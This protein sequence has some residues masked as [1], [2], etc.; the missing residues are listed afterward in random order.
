MSQ[1][2]LTPNNPGSIVGQGELIFSGYF[3]GPEFS[4]NVTIPAGAYY[5]RSNVTPLAISAPATYGRQF[6]NTTTINSLTTAYLLLEKPE[7]DLKFIS[8]VNTI[9]STFINQTTSFTGAS[10]NIIHD[11]TNFLFVANN[12]SSNAVNLYYSTDAIS[13]SL[14]TLPSVTTSPI[15]GTGRLSFNYNSSVTNKYIY[16]MNTANA[17]NQIGY[18]TDSVT[19]TLASCAAS[20][21]G[22]TNPQINPNLTEK[23]LVHLVQSS[24]NTTQIAT[25]T[26]AVTWNT[27]TGP[28]FSVF[29]FRNIV[30]NGGSSGEVYV[31]TTNFTT[32]NVYTSTDGITWSSRSTGALTAAGVVN[33][34][35]GKWV[36]MYSANNFYTFVT[37]TD[38]I[39]WTLRYFKSGV[40]GSSS[41]P[42]TSRV[43]NNKMWVQQSSI[44]PIMVSTD[45]IDWNANTTN[46][47]SNL[48]S[49]PQVYV[50]G[51]YY[52]SVNTA[53]SSS[54]D[55]TYV[56]LYK[57]DNQV[58]V[59]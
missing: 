24:G 18:S 20:S 8:S 41:D 33:Y 13:W 29:T 25:S 52:S 11:G 28:S 51:K 1:D 5:V 7:S 58:K 36:V 53:I 16:T 34:I 23:Y 12:A 2:L 10:G 6:I 17:T 31:G 43:L 56:A 37:S 40:L 45:G 32:Q 14:R 19:W 39:T 38:A 47:F 57:M 30:G 9:S 15:W 42:F 3:E 59:V 4:P 54:M 26:D 27:R 35:D 49:L 22:P 48:S 21:S 50:N 46:A 44:Q 55:K